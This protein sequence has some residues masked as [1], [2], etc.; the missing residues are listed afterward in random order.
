LNAASAF[1]Q[2]VPDES[3]TAIW[4]LLI[5]AARN[6]KQWPIDVDLSGVAVILQRAANPA[7]RIDLQKRL[8]ASLGNGRQSRDP[9]SATADFRLWLANVQAVLDATP[10][11]PPPIDAF[12]AVAGSPNF[13]LEVLKAIGN[14]SMTWPVD[15]PILVSDEEALR[16]LALDVAAS[17]QRWQVYRTEIA[18]LIRL[19]AQ[20]DWQSTLQS[21]E[22]MIATASAMHNQHTAIGSLFEFCLLLESVGK[23][24]EATAFLD[25]YAEHG[26]NLYMLLRMRPDRSAAWVAVALITRD[27]STI[28]NEVLASSIDN[29][30]ERAGESLMGSLRRP[31]QNPDFLTEIGSALERI[32]PTADAASGMRAV[33][34]AI[35]AKG[36]LRFRPMYPSARDDDSTKDDE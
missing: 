24:P 35:E 28:G 31:E 8:L 1:A 25:A 7:G 2:L 33:A 9:D 12:D 13:R 32:A 5:D 27:P 22:Q 11:T 3:H 26:G 18:H 10:A 36:G 19:G 14:G 34:A 23:R 16:K 20:W 4:Q 6:V 30:V 29:S 21:A 15:P 17:A